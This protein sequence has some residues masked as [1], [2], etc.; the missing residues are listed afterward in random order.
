MK[1][2]F[3][4][5]EILLMIGTTFSS[6]QYCE[7][8]ENNKLLSENEKLEEACWNGMMRVM[9]PEIFIQAIKS[10]IYIW[11][12]REAVSFLDLEIG[13]FPNEISRQFSINP[14]FFLEMHSNN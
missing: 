6:G 12:I 7:L 3:I 11:K 2:D 1:N 4:Q 8:E 10:K 13:E 9:L 14:Y 5:L